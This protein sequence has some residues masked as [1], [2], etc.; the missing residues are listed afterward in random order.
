MKKV[1][2]IFNFAQ[3]VGGGELSF[4]DLVDEIRGCGVQPVVFV[5]GPGAVKD[6]LAAL[7]VPIHEFPWP[8]VRP[9]SLVDLPRQQ[10]RLAGLF[11]TLGLDLVHVNG[12]RCMLYAGPAARRAGIPCVWHVRV[13]E[14]DKLL[15]RIRA[16]YATAVIA[17]SRAAAKTI[18]PLLPAK[19]RCAVVYNGL[20]LDQLLAAPAADL[21][22]EFGLPHGPVIL[23]VGRFSRGKAFDDLIRACRILKQK[24]APFSCLL[25]GRA[26]PE[27]ADCEAGLQALAGSLDLK[28]ELLFPGWRDDVPSIMK[29]ASVFVLPSRVEAFGRGIPEAWACGLPIVATDEGGPAELITNNVNGLLVQVG[30]VD[31]IAQAIFSILQDSALAQRLARAGRDK[32]KEFSLQNHARLISEVYEKICP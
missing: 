15:D 2:Y 14:R 13:L 25:V 18:R 3:I 5:P 1:G 19:A 11:K 6:R 23:G 29:A 21:A 4:L 20:R 22:A 27:E 12:A 26:V 16:R 24:N 28:N 10:T 31:A 17:N 8:P 30:D 7:G 32:A 9:R